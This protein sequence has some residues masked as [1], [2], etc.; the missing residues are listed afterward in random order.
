MTMYQPATSMR[1][2]QMFRTP[3]GRKVRYTLTR[4]VGPH[5][6][7]L[8]AHFEYVEAGRTVGGKAMPELLTLRLPNFRILVAL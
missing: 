1:Q 2:G 5:P 3:L 4:K 7:D 6:A 8:E